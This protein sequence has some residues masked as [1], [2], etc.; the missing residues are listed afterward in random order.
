MVRD[1]LLVRLAALAIHRRGGGDRRRRVV[2]AALDDFSV[3]GRGRAKRVGRG[4]ASRREAREAG[5][6]AVA[7]VPLDGVVLELPVAVA[8]EEDL[9]GARSAPRSTRNWMTSA[10]LNST[11]LTSNGLVEKS[12]LLIR[13]LQSSATRFEA[14]SESPVSSAWS[15]SRWA[16]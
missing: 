4:A 6:R 9:A 5:R 10:L 1:L 15:I 13:N 8:L 16:R 11:A 7:Q 12:S 3:G 14:S 2:P